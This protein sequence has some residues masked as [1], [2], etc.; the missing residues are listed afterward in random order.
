VLTTCPWQAFTHPVVRDVLDLYRV[1][2]TGSEPGD[3]H[4]ASVRALNPP[5]HL[6]DGVQAYAHL[7]AKNIEDIRAADAARNSKR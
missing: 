2:R 1:A 7:V 6:W 4:L 3:V 5:A